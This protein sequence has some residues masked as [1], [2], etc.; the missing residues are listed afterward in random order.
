[1]SILVQTTYIPIKSTCTHN[2]TCTDTHT[3]TSTHIDSVHMR[4]DTYWYTQRI[5][6]TNS[7]MKLNLSLF[8]K[9]VKK[10]R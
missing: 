9:K 8:F 7:L 2:D 5:E 4:I 3:D 1:M 6:R 10:M